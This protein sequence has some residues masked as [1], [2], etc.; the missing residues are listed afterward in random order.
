MIFLTPYDTLQLP[1]G[2]TRWAPPQDFAPNK[3]VFRLVSRPELAQTDMNI[4]YTFW[5]I[6]Y[7]LRGLKGKICLIKG[8]KFD[9]FLYSKRK[10]E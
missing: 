8:N 6:K 7:G 4:L 3:I 5:P 2:V 1:M 9:V 10:N